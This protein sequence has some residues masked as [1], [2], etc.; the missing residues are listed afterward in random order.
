MS[1]NSPDVETSLVTF[2][3]CFHSEMSAGKPL[4]S[5]RT[6]H[7][8]WYSIAR[9]IEK[10]L[11]F[12][13]PARQNPNKKREETF[14][15][16]QVVGRC[17]ALVSIAA[18]RDAIKK[19]PNLSMGSILLAGDII[20]VRRIPASL[21]HVENSKTQRLWQQYV[22]ENNLKSTSST[23]ES[24]ESVAERLQIDQ[25][26]LPLLRGI[27]HNFD[28]SSQVQR[29]KTLTVEQQLEQAE[30]EEECHSSLQFT[31]D[32]TEQQRLTLICTAGTL[33]LTAANKTRIGAVGTE[34]TGNTGGADRRVIGNEDRKRKRG[35]YPPRNYVCKR[36]G[37]S[38]HWYNECPTHG[39]AKFDVVRKIAC[40][41]IPRALLRRI[42][43]PEQTSGATVMVRGDEAFKHVDQPELFEELL[44][45]RA[46]KAK[47]ARKND[48]KIEQIQTEPK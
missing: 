1:S 21:Y 2:Y 31:D 40:T 25:S 35:R 18:M 29:H 45:G 36:C 43:M 24:P 38:G 8:F 3:Y 32:M 37:I 23:Y 30:Q 5:M 27:Q 14:L 12:N 10:Q 6:E 44:H 28:P 9:E 11:Q 33:L 15:Q 17:Q 26:V 20:V 39:D 4:R 34:G 41:G 48:S 19:V 42:D 16:G 47:R 13:A 22:A 7:R 46:S